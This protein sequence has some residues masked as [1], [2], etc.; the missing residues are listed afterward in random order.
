MTRSEQERL[1]ERYLSGEM[2]S[3][4][5][6]EFF[7]QVAVNQDLRQTLKAYRI[8]ES[9]I[10]KHRDNAPTHHDQSRSRLI[11]M[12]SAHAAAHPTAANPAA[13]HPT[14][15]GNSAARAAGKS[16]GRR[17]T[18]STATLQWIVG[19]VAVF[20]CVLGT[21]IV[22][23]LIN[24]SPTTPQPRPQ[25]ADVATKI[26]AN[27]SAELFVAPPVIS[28][29]PV[30]EPSP[31]PGSASAVAPAEH[32]DPVAP[33]SAVKRHARPRF[34]ATGMKRSA[35]PRETAAV[36]DTDAAPS[37]DA[38]ATTLPRRSQPRIIVRNRD[39]KVHV[40]TSPPQS[41]PK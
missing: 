6:E 25:Q 35:K 23:P 33:P 27:A 14:A 11:A 20:A 13:A 7:M 19:S 21:F 10:R 28:N 2:V 41:D 3:A 37:S 16:F 39:I 22:A 9:A 1:V 24:N 32:A 18:V 29:A 36:P 15:A 12:L 26:P 4:D 17:V 30:P 38:K 40:Q 8:M 34:D 5:E 31:G